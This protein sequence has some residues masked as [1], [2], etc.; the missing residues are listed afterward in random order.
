MPAG[1][2]DALLVRPC[3][4]APACG[5]SRERAPADPDL[6]VVQKY[7]ATRDSGPRNKRRSLVESVLSGRTTAPRAG[8]GS[9]EGEVLRLERQNVSLMRALGR[10]EEC[11]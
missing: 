7:G 9:L 3:V 11:R 5:L 6:L 1:L 8:S 4:E 10:E 2:P